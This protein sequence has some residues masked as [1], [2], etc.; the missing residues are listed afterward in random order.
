MEP[1]LVTKLIWYSLSQINFLLFVQMHFG[2]LNGI[3]FLI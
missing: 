1:K 2:I 3:L